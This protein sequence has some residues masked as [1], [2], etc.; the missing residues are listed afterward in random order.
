MNNDILKIES[1]GYKTRLIQSLIAPWFFIVLVLLVVLSLFNPFIW[2]IVV[3]FTALYFVMNYKAMKYYLTKIELDDENLR[4][5]YLEYDEP[6]PPLIIPIK[7]LSVDYFDNG[8]GVSSLVSNHV[9]IGRKGNIIIRQYQ[10]HDWSQ[11]LM[12]SMTENLREIR[13]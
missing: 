4:F 11:E 3:L 12:K 13:K 5:T 9:C 1:I 2:T 6:K 7:E 8:K 10:T